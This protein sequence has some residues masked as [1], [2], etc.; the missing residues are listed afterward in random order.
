MASSPGAGWSQE[1]Y[2]VFKD[3]GVDV[4]TYV[5]EGGVKDLIGLCA[6]DDT[7]DM[8]PLTNESEGPCLL[9]GSWLAGKKGVLL[10]QGS[11]AGNCINNFG[12]NI[13]GRFPLLTVVALRGSWSE[14]N[15]WMI[16]QGRTM[17]RIFEDIGFKVYEVDKIEDAAPTIEAALKM[18]YFADAQVAVILSQR[19]TGAKEFKR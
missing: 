6:A 4:V 17:H 5:P 7:M 14:G 15:Y 9:A 1:V 2:R 11:G 12:L 10:M 18:A 13:A 19:L 16:Y 8:V 3:N